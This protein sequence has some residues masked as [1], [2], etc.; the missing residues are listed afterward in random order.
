M[1]EKSDQTT[2]R[3]RKGKHRVARPFDMHGFADGRTSPVDSTK[4]LAAGGEVMFLRLPDVKALT[5]LSKTS[6][7]SLIRE[8]D[9]PAPIRLGPRAVA[10]VRSSSPAIQA[11]RWYQRAQSSLF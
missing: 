9:F 8:Q 3:P 1:T 7:Y 5:G 11:S 10:W 4:I 2:N 6:L